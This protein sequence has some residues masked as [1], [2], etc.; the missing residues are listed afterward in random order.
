MRRR[1]LLFATHDD[2]RLDEGFSYAVELAKTLDKDLRVLLVAEKKLSDKLDDI[3]AA[4]AFAEESGPDTAREMVKGGFV[5]AD[6]DLQK[7]LAPQFYKGRS[8]GVGVEVYTAS[9]KIVQAINGFIKEYPGVDM[10]LLGPTVTDAGS[11]SA[12]ELKKLV[13][14]VSR[15]VVTM[16]RHALGT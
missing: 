9:M 4:V 6:E 10:V 2:A 8:A 1:Q 11:V 7:K 15:P 13:T 3:M 5:M 14:S 16:A 12:R